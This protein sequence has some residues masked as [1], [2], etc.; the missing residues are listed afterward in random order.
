[1]VPSSP[2]V[3]LCE[4]SRQVKVGVPILQGGAFFSE[5]G[6]CEAAARLLNRKTQNFLFLLFHPVLPSLS[7][8][9]LASLFKYTIAV[10]RLQVYCLVGVSGRLYLL[11]THA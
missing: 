7:D 2:R 11:P 6:Q 9:D 8:V 3:P 4:P 5:T 10:L 1:M